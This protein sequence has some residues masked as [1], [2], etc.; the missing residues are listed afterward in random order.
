MRNDRKTPRMMAPPPAPPA[1]VYVHGPGAGGQRRLVLPV[2]PLPPEPPPE[3]D[4]E[5][6]ADVFR[7]AFDAMVG[8]L[9]SREACRLAGQ[10]I[11]DVLLGRGVGGGR[12]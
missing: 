5:D 7:G 3:Q 11:G 9:G 6:P 10:L 12:G 4:D 2:M 1:P 8:C